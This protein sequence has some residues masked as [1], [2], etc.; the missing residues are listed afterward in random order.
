MDY[1]L[2]PH[3]VKILK[4]L[5]CR[6]TPDEIAKK[7]IMPLDAVM[8]A[9]SWLGTKNLV[10]IEEKITEEIV[11]DKEGVLY[12]ETGLPER[13]IIEAAGEEISLADL[14]KKFSESEINISLGWLNRKKQAILEKVLIK[15]DCSSEPN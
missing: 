13:R 1:E 4:E 10:K 3:E 5:E 9:S 8:R 15:I 12:A 14:K 7:A 11:L 6:S 2:H